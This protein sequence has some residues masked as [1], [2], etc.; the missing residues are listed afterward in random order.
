MRMY[1][2]LNGDTESPPGSIL[3]YQNYSAEGVLYVIICRETENVCTYIMCT[4]IAQR[5]STLVVCA[6]CSVQPAT[7]QKAIY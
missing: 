3:E 7:W 2:N 1:Q 6:R 4:G 5:G